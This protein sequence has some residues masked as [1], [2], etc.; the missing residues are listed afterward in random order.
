[1]T[2]TVDGVGLHRTEAVDRQTETVDK[3]MV[4]GKHRNETVCMGRVR[5]RMVAR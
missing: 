5:H 1:M 4:R 2:Q 3:W